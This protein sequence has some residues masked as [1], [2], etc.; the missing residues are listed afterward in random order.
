MEDVPFEELLTSFVGFV[1]FRRLTAIKPPDDPGVYVIVRKD[2]HAPSFRERSIGGHFKGKDPT[3]EVSVLEDKWVE[4]ATVLYIGKATSL[5]K[6]LDQYRRF[7][8]G[9]RVGHW[10]GRYIWQCEDCDDFLVAWQVTDEDPRE[11]EL[12][13][14]ARFVDEYGRS[15]FANIAG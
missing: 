14:L 6:R 3:V 7:G 10:G 9:A 2:P 12:R 13:L 1:P 4:G 5:R 8:E 11:V 15:P